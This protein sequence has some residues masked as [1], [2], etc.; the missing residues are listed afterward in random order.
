MRQ[1]D[2]DV[3]FRKGM[4][5]WRQR[6]QEAKKALEKK[7]AEW[8]AEQESRVQQAAVHDKREK[9]ALQA[10]KKAKVEAEA[11][12]ARQDSRLDKLAAKNAI[13]CLPDTL[14]VGAPASISSIL[15]ISGCII[16]RTH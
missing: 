13:R 8:K 10:F 2:V 12:M 4:I 5:G 6:Q 1:D 9:E 11:V 14:F 16:A 3:Y 15:R 7:K